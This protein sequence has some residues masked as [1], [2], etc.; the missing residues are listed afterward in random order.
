MDE[1]ELE[2]SVA[3]ERRQR[4]AHIKLCIHN[5]VMQNHDQIPHDA[6][7]HQRRRLR[8][9]EYEMTLYSE[10]SAQNCDRCFVSP[11]HGCQVQES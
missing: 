11:T 2:A 4:I 6:T 3:R 7:I 5:L 1:Q 10:R 8:V 9:D